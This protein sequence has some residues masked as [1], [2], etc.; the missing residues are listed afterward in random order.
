MKSNPHNYPLQQNIR[1]IAKLIGENHEALCAGEAYLFPLEDG[2]GRS[3]R[4][5]FEP[6]EESIRNTLVT[7]MRPLSVLFPTQIIELEIT[8]HYWCDS[9][10]H[11]GLSQF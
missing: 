4:G 3:F 1:Y 2:G 5:I 10:L 6:S 8:D 11:F 9:H 7:E